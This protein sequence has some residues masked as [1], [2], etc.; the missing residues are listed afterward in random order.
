MG[1]IFSRWRLYSILVHVLKKKLK[2][3]L[4]I[5]YLTRKNDKTNQKDKRKYQLP[6]ADP[7]AALGDHKYMS[8]V[9][10]WE[11]GRKHYLHL[12]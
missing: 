1:A 11:V 9:W 10:C 2:V 5:A 6:K 8:I 12:P 7:G 4:E 3:Q